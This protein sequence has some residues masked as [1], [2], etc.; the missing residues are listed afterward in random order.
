MNSIFFSLMSLLIISANPVNIG[1]DAKPSADVNYWLTKSDKSVLLAKQSTVL[2]FKKTDNRNPTILI[3]ASKT[4][5]KIEGFGYAL[6]GGSAQLISSLEPAVK[7]QLLQELFGSKENGI[8]VSYLRISIGASDLDATVFSYDDLPANQTDVSLKKFSLQP[9]KAFLIPIIKE[10]LLINPHIKIMACPWS[11]PVWMKDNNSSKGGSLQLKY[12]D[13]YAKYFVKYIQEM[14]REGITIDAITPQNEPLHPGNNPSLLMLAA[15]QANFIKNNLGP[16]F[17]DSK[18]ATKII[19]YDHNCNKPE[20]P[21]SILND[22]AAKKYITGSAFHLYEGGIEALTKVHEA[23]PDKGLYFT[24]QW[25]SSEGD[26]GG[27]LKWH[28]K[29]VVIG[30]MQNWSRSAL[31][32]NLANDPN[33][34]PHTPGG[35]TQCKGAIT[36]NSPST[37]SKNV[38]FYIIAHAS[39]FVPAGSIKIASNT[40]G[41]LSNVAFKTPS[42]KIVLIVENDGAST[43]QF[44][45][46][47]Q[48]QQVNTS[49]DAGAVAT[50]VW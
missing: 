44:N 33:F 20:Y 34:G 9:D 50:Y 26:F 4:A 40:F 29:N 39:K 36:I 6:T 27:D 14:K 47:Y 28:I 43:E 19:I 24:E 17:A 5:Q 13:V 41:N 16:A 35:C 22:A 11:P 42:G 45:I 37:Y 23:H 7:K 15:D 18:I 8:G 12:Y 21:I 31:E 25:T 46:Q 48:D 10:I 2:H 49:L 1:S 30:S 32:W 38:S 3:D